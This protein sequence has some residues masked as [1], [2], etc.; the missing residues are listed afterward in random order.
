MSPRVRCPECNG[1]GEHWDGD[2]VEDC[3]TCDGTG[4]IDE[5]EQHPSLDE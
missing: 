1:T 2:D 4:K 5:P 3:D